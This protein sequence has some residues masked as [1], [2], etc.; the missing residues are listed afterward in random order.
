VLDGTELDWPFF[1]GLG[2]DWVSGR[3]ADGTSISVPLDAAITG[4]TRAANF[5]MGW[6]GRDRLEGTPES[7]RIAGEGVLIEQGSDGAWSLVLPQIAIAQG[8]TADDVLVGGAGPD[9]LLGEYGEDQL[10]AEDEA[11]YG[12]LI[13]RYRTQQGA[14]TIGDT[15]DGGPGDDQIFGGA[16]ND[17]LLGGGGYDLI[18]AG[19]G[20]DVVLSDQQF[21]SRHIVSAAGN[22][23]Y[24]DGLGAPIPIQ[25]VT[26]GHDGLM[27]PGFVLPTRYRNGPVAATEQGN[28][29]IHGGNG[30]DI[31]HAGEGRD[32]IEGDAGDDTLHGEAG[33]DFL[34]GGTGTNFLFGGAG[35]D[36]YLLTMGANDTIY[37]EQGENILMLTVLPSALT[38]VAR[39]YGEPGRGESKSLNV[40]LLYANGVQFA[41]LVNFMDGTFGTVTFVGS[42]TM[43]AKTFIARFVRREDAALTPGSYPRRD[44]QRGADLPVALGRTRSAKTSPPAAGPKSTP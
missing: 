17:L 1:F 7:D 18:F 3:F 20:D 37:D 26:R 44:W 29:W 9:V 5:L 30:N 41:R 8:R 4:P 38:V 21:E 28:D 31:I 40:L 33:D 11:R 42:E 24:Y 43:D 39:Q 6:E 32:R 15:L 12:D 19:G 22:I 36:Q 2:D 10:Y 27:A 13:A 25:L 16:G 23:A 14:G 34:M 35:N